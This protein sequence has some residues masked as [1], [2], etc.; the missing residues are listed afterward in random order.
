MINEILS[1]FKRVKGVR[2]C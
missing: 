2:L 1:L